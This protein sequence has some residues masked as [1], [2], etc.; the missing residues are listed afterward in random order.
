MTLHICLWPPR[1]DDGSERTLEQDAFGF[2]RYCT[3]FWGT[4]AIERVGATMLSRL[5]TDHLWVTPAER[6][7]LERQALLVWTYAD[8]IA[9]EVFDADNPGRGAVIVQTP[10]GGVLHDAF[11]GRRPSDSVRRYADNL[12]AAIGVAR[13][14]DCG[15]VIW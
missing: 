9:A 14:E 7:A 4:D 1:R 11:G 3:D 8:D 6:D 5:R 13:A 12:L 15:L 10:E 2:E